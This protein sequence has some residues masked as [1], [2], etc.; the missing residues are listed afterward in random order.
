MD[1][2]AFA[3]MK[4]IMEAEV[5]VEGSG[6]VAQAAE[7]YAASEGGGVVVQRCTVLA[8]GPR[9]MIEQVRKL[10]IRQSTADVHFDLHEE[11]FAW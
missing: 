1:G 2:A 10:C 9:M 5:K 4:G 3:E 8:C 11:E 6:G 7:G